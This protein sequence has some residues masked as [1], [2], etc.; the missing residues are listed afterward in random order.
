MGKIR[1]VTDED[2]PFVRATDRTDR[3][4]SDP[5]GPSKE[6]IDGAS[7]RHH[8][9]GSDGEPQLFEVRIDPGVE[10]QSH[11]HGEDEIIAVV[12]GELQ[13]GARTCRAGSSIFVAGDT[14]YGFRAG[15]EGVRFLNFRPRADTRYVSKAGYMAT[16]G[17]ATGAAPDGE[18][19]A[20]L[21]ED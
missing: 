4:R 13:V 5:Y 15:P 16:R 7:V 8:H 11:A 14:L 18:A 19:P 9:R 12:E 2:E 3:D 6:E 1:I 21:R 10:V 17:R 20:E